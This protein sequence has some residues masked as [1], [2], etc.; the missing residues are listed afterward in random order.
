MT[1]LVGT[2]LKHRHTRDAWGVG[3]LAVHEADGA[4]RMS[5]CILVGPTLGYAAPGERL[6]LEGEWVT[7][8]GK[9]GK[10][11]KISR[12]ESAGVVDEHEAS[13]W[14]TRLAGVGPVLA[15]RIEAHFP[16]RVLK[17]LQSEPEGH[18]PLLL[19]EGIGPVLARS[20]RESWAE[21]GAAGDPEDLAYLDGIGLTRW[22]ASAV[23][24]LAKQ[25]GEKP[26]ALLESD[27]YRLMEIHGFGFARADRVAQRSGVSRDAPARVEAGTLH[28]LEELCECDTMVAYGRLV[29]QSARALEVE[30][31]LVCE[32]LRRMAVDERIV[33]TLD[34]KVCWVHLPELLRA[35]REILRAVRHSRI[36]NVAEE[37]VGPEEAG[38]LAELVAKDPLA[39]EGIDAW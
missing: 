33:Q 20:I 37:K 17:E 21:V 18:D 24:V 23:L 11:F 15:K 22:E 10:Q 5:E 34:G 36:E 25:H 28:M 2:L 19:V 14:L 9:Y 4:A 13:R 7:D 39:V 26:Q 1:R 16:G 35:E 31:K 38:L 32:A 27:P 6:I 12:Q 8:R 29:N 30:G 3:D